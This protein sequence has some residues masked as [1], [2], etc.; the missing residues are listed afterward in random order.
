MRRFRAVASD[1]PAFASVDLEAGVLV[2]D[3]AALPEPRGVAYHSS[4]E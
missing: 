4:G 2:W 1:F 3:V